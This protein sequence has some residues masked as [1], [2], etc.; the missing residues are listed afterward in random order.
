MSADQDQ[1]WL[2]WRRQGIG[3]SD[4]AGILGISPWTTPYSVWLTKT[5]GLDAEMSIAMELG[6]LLEPFVLGKYE[7]ATGLHAIARQLRCTHPEH[8]H[9]RAT[10]D[11]AA[12]ETTT[13]DP[14][15][16]WD[17]TV[18]L[19][20]AKTTG[21]WSWDTVPDHY[22]AQ[23]QW[24][25]HVTGQQLCT[26]A[27]LHDRRSFE[28]YDVE[29]DDEDIAILVKAVDEF[30]TDHVLAGTPPEVTGRDLDAVRWAHRK[31]EAGTAMTADDD[32]VTL[33]QQLDAAK[34]TGKA[35]WAYVEQLTAQLIARID[36]AETVT[37][38]TGRQ[39]VTYK[40]TR[41]FDVAA[42]TAEHPD[43]A[44]E[45]TVPTV[46]VDAFKKA[47]GRKATERYMRPTESRRLYFP[48]RKDK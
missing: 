40:A 23:A 28:L 1:E 5:A 26:F 15:E 3:G 31:V 34:A 18:A 19:V 20:E 43:L 35:H 29:R 9:H 4:V 44:A 39:L 37:D 11:A 24:Q 48:T 38:G 21:E 30:W 13:F 47:L 12:V 14:A 6:H 32:L 25:M 16:L 46:D 36:T 2:E 10:I 8:E 45:H 7:Q 42:A 41:A 33:L 22:Y 17:H 27:V